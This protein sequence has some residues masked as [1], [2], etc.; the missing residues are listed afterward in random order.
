[1]KTKTWMRTQLGFWT[2]C[3]VL[4]SG[5]AA[6]QIETE[7]ALPRLFVE[8]AVGAVHSTVV[9]LRLDGTEP[10]STAWL[11]S[12]DRPADFVTVRS[13]IEGKLGSMRSALGSDTRSDLKIEPM[14]PAALTSF[15]AQASASFAWHMAVVRAHDGAF[16]FSEPAATPSGSITASFSGAAIQTGFVV[17]TEFMKDPT[18]VSDSSGEWIEVYNGGPH[19]FDLEGSVLSDDGSNTHLIYNG[20]N[21]LVFLPGQRFV[22]GANA[23]M[24]ANGGVEVDYDYSS[25]SLTNG[26]DEIVVTGRN[27]LLLDRV[28]YDDGVS[29]PDQSGSSISL[30]EFLLDAFSNDDPSNW[31]HSQSALNGSNS[32][33]GTPGLPNELC[34]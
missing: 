15:V 24:A 8:D 18:S 16:R 29:W 22:L 1:M 9:D 33:T 7:R 14:T 17:V 13:R 2:A 31:C 23:D 25:F 6:N 21:G 27:G 4:N 19:R 5:V 34:P 26:A 30:H 32:D 3:V 10:F 11:V 12:S 28:A 20:G